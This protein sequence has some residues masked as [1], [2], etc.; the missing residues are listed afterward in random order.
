M[1]NL[2]KTSVAKTR[3][4][5]KLT[6]VPLV[7]IDRCQRARPD[8]FFMARL[9]RNL[10]VDNDMSREWGRGNLSGLFSL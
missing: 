10:C 5:R 6:L 7:R 9:N 2:N 8:R 3:V 4:E 1:V